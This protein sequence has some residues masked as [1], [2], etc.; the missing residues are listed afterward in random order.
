M[1]AEN[2]LKDFDKELIEKENLNTEI[3]N[4]LKECRRQL[5]SEI[6]N[7]VFLLTINKIIWDYLYRLFIY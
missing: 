5:T 4:E 7:F 2:R 6:V 1:K 3:K